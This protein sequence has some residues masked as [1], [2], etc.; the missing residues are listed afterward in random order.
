V[1][2]TSVLIVRERRF[3]PLDEKLQLRSDHWSEGAA[4]V[5]TRHGL[6]G[7]SFEAAAET[8]RDAV[9]GSISGSSVRRISEGFGGQLTQQKQH[10]A[11]Q[12]SGIARV[13]ESPRERRVALQDPVQEQANLSSDGTMLLVRGEGWKEV[14]MATISQVTVLEAGHKQRRRAQREGKRSDEA[15]VRLSQHSYCAGLWD[16]DGFEAYQYTEGLRRGLDLVDRLSSVN[17]GAAWIER[18][19]QT[20]FPQAIQII[21]WSHAMERL[22]TVANTV[23][24]EG[25]QAA[26]WVEEREQELWDGQ[27]EQV[28][29]ALDALDLDQHSYPDPVRQAPGYFRS[30]RE[31]MR[32]HVFRA[33]GY[34]IGSGTVES[35]AKNVVQHRMRR[36]GRGWNR[37]SGQ[38]MLTALGELHSGRF[39]SAWNRAGQPAPSHPKF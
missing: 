17:D 8:Y 28:I 19:T 31:R 38:A 12:A 29:Q 2:T 6:Q 7:S 25:Q 18:V 1:P 30:N 36:P 26:S 11:Q 3:F 15:V 32:Y 10:E 20:N 27:V 33:A 23:Y 21:D 14:K 9:G 5:A 34:P 4:R 35:G 16:A 39:Q 37:D 24:G 22:W 13:G